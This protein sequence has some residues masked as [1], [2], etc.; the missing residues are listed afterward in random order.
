MPGLSLGANAGFAVPAAS[1]PPSY[2]KEPAGRTI[3][4]RAYGIAEA[5]AGEG[6]PVAGTG[7]VGVGLA[8]TALLVWLWYSLP[9]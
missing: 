8:A 7:S 5:S 6:R 4:A 9:R 1:L 2:S 3:S